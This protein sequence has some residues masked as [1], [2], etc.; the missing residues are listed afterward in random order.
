[1]IKK[2]SI[3]DLSELMDLAKLL[4]PTS[5]NLESEIR[6]FLEDQEACIFV[7]YQNQPLGFVICKIR[8]DYVEGTSSD[9]VA[10]IEGLF[11]KEGYRGQKIA[12]NLVQNCASWSKEKGCKQMA[13]DCDLQNTSSINFHKAIGFDQVNTIVCFVKDL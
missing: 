8:H 10:Y 2:A 12:Q 9:N 11:V 3:Q 5:E 4:W 1:M 6:A 13:S 7:D